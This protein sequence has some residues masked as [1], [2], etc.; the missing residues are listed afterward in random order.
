MQ[1]HASAKEAGLLD[2]SKASSTSPGDAAPEA[3]REGGAQGGCCR[4]LV[5]ILCMPLLAA[6]TL[7]RAIGL[8]ETA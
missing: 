6:L 4:W 3:S 1:P 7:V 5:V 8:P 2:T